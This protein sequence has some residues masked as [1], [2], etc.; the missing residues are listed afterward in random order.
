MLWLYTE[1]DSLFA[2]VLAPPHGRAHDRA[3]GRAVL[4]ALGLFAKADHILASNGDGQAIWSPL[5]AE[6]LGGLK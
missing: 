5:L 3:V 6:C 1:N 2:P 4:K